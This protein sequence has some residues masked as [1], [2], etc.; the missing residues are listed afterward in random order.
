MNLTM[1]VIVAVCAKGINRRSG[2]CQPLDGDYKEND[3]KLFKFTKQPKLHVIIMIKC[4]KG[5]SYNSR[6][7]SSCSR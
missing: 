7:R 1:L 4:S 5:N 6:C 2:H 3:D